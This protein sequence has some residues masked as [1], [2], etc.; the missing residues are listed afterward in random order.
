LE[1]RT[2]PSTINWINR[3]SDNFATVFGGNAN[4]A[5]SVVDTAIDEWQSVI[6]NF[7]QL[8]NGDNNHIN[9]TI[10]MN[11]AAGSS[12]GK[13]TPIFTDPSGKPIAATIMLG[14]TSDGTNPWFLDPN[15]FSSAFLDTPSNAFAGYAQSGSPATGE[16]DLMEVITHELGHA[17]GFYSSPQVNAHCSDT[18]IGDTSSSD[19]LHGDYWA[20]V[21]TG[22]FHCL[23]TAFNTPASDKHGGE[24]FAAGGFLNFGGNQYY[25]AD[26]LMTPYYGN[27]QRR[28]VSRNDAFVLRDSYGYTVNDPASVLG[29]FYALIDPATGNLIVRGRQDAASSDGLTVDTGTIFP[30][31]P[32]VT[33]SVSLGTPVPGT[34]YTGPY[35]FSFYTSTVASIEIDTGSGVSGVALLHAPNVPITINSS[36]GLVA[37]GTGGNAQGVLGPITLNDTD[38]LTGLV[39]DDSA[40]P[41]A[42][43]ITM[44]DKG[45]TTCGQITGLIPNP[46]SYFNSQ[47]GGVHINTG[48]G[49]NI[50]NVY[51]TGPLGVSLEG[52]SSS[53]TV[54]VGNG[55]V[56][57]IRGTVSIEN[58]P[59]YTTINIDDS[60]D[61]SARTTTL[62]TYTPFGDAPWGYI[63]GLAPVDI[64]YEY[65]DTSSLTIRT[66]KA[67]GNVIRV[68]ED[69]VPTNLIGNSTASVNI[70]DGLVGVQN[71]LGTLNIE[72]PP[73]VTT[74]WID[75]TADPSTRTTTLGTYTPAG[76][77]PW[78]YITGLAPADIH[79]EYAD[80]A[81]L[82]INGSRVNGNVTRVWEDGVTTN[83]I[84]NA[85]ANVSIGDG[86]VGVR[87]ILGTLN[88]ENPPSYTTI[89][90]DDTA[91]PSART[92]IL[93][94]YT[95]LGDTP[96]GY[97]TGLAPAE[98]HY[99]YA[100][101]SGLTIN[102]SRVNGNVI[103]VRADG[104]PT[105]LIGNASANVNI[106]DGVVGVQNILGTLNIENPPSYTT[107]N[108]D[109]SADASAWTTTLGTYTPSG[110][111]P[112]GYITGL[113]PAHINYEYADVTSVTIQSGANGDTFQVAN[114][115][116]VPVILNG[117][118]GTNTLD[119]PNQANSWTFNAAHGG[120]L[121]SN[122]AFNS[123]QSLAGGNG[124]D[125]FTLSSSVPVA[126][127]LKLNS[128]G[129]LTT[130]SGSQTL[131][132][133]IDTQGQRLTVDGAGNT[134]L[135]GVIS[136]LGGLAKQ[137][138]GTL[139]LSAANTYQD[140]T[141]VLAG[142]LVA[143]APNVLTTTRALQVG[144][145]ATF[146]LNNNNQQIGLLSDYLG[147][148]G[149]VLLGSATLSLGN[150]N[151]SATF[152]G[153]ISGSG[154]LSKLGT[155]T[156]TLSGA[157]TYTGPTL[158]S[159]GTLRAGKI[160]T[161]PSASNVGVASGAILDLNNLNQTIGSLSDIS[162]GGGAVSLGS[163]MLTVGNLNVPAN[164][165]GAISGSGALTLVGGAEYL[166]GANT[167]TG[168]T[169]VQAGT[170]VVNGSLA[171]ASPVRVVAS[172]ELAGTGTVGAVTVSGSGVVSPGSGG[173]GILTTGTAAF[174]PTSSFVTMLDSTSS[175]GQLNATGAV[176]LTR[177]P[178]LIV[179]PAYNAAVGDVFTIV[180]SPAGVTGTFA[181]L[182]E[183][184]AFTVN[185]QRFQI[186]YNP[187]SV[188]L[189]RI[190][191]PATHF[192]VGAVSST[193]AGAPFDFTVI[194]LDAQ[195]HVDTAYTGTVQFSSLDPHLPAGATFNPVTYTFTVG[196]NGDYG[197]HTF[198]GG[199]TL[200]TAGTW[201]VTVTDMNN[202]S[203][204]GS[205]N[206]Q[207]TPAAADHL[208]F[209]QPPTDTAAT[210]TIS[211]A[212][213]VA[214]VDQFGNVETG[215]NSDTVTLS[216]GANPGGGALGGTLSGTVSGG[217]ATFGD[218]SI[219][220]AGAGYTLHATIGGGLPDIDS[221]PFNIL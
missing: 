67:S 202:Q 152:S 88:I 187:T 38:G 162:G 184:T 161:L 94:T 76:D 192:Q 26:D 32:V 203:L 37:L 201:D 116:W 35:T 215:D 47:L 132:A 25:G 115:P 52:H 221:N 143:G 129:T 100:D 158:V 121:D 16:G 106:G 208:L 185:G 70:G 159:G 108:I 22:G 28:I 164:F 84:G 18:G 1:D 169:T 166:Y 49:T 219:D 30:G 171:A 218:L 127:N 212:V 180:T 107:I 140:T 118:G 124:G 46:I 24:H 168:P 155:T 105:N 211:P 154:S 51:S 110:D 151:F 217:V 113:A 60:A 142:A 9:V 6:V 62:G 109:D 68:W 98:I 29:T 8:F 133:A 34:D 61:A 131:T 197:R 126:M 102:G 205:A 179:Q 177:Q 209:L 101:T 117:T 27:G 134:T 12:G 137:G 96:W 163:A 190:G 176:D 128:A 20:F 114:V 188:V 148:G 175:Y 135:Q 71:I 157:N 120:V 111:S 65:E 81:N 41:A 21:G 43:T 193:Q 199:A 79:Y 136:G 50:V 189:E 204:I 59:S 141:V 64:H 139:T 182:P 56:Q 86:L 207:V 173:Q 75:D 119:G 150:D 45:G 82:T 104:V 149:S 48:T 39:V 74:I 72:N 125:T 19:G 80:T 58:A 213:A 57:N 200:Y 31:T 172:G 73:S 144:S 186:F 85:T 214:V 216:I 191:N 178:A 160:N 7:H 194:A 33:T 130:P 196:A 55:N 36:N 122:V 183:G 112:W 145:G 54:N 103:R 198:V 153:A 10:S 2:V 63:S 42:H 156:Q 17:M 206:V 146:D 95:P 40:D 92:S 15:L 174:S 91:D 44:A 78:G 90:I 77:S 220:Q 195:G 3:G 123:F 99:E 13:T 167:Y 53:T 97:I 138:S 4:L 89:N 147:G 83:L 11:T 170:L 87:N 14:R 181:N 165:H 23:L 93:G 69:G 210:Q 66:G 5:R